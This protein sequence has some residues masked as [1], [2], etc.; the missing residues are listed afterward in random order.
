MLTPLF[1]ATAIGTTL[2][3]VADLPEE[4]VEV[5]YEALVADDNRAAV[6]QLEAA[7]EEQPGHPAILLNLGT[8]YARIGELSAA[9]EAFEAARDARD[10]FEVELADGEWIDTAQ[11]ARLALARLDGPQFATR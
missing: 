5:A 4:R 1:F 2:P 11:A 7:L 9:R 6:A 8:A 3:P 10:R